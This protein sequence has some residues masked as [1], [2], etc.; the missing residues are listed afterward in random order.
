MSP[1][2]TDVDGFNSLAELAL[3]TLPMA[4]DGALVGWVVWRMS[5]GRA[6]P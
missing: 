5:Y 3:W 4:L 6:A 2:H 1:L